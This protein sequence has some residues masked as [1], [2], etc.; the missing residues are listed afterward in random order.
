MTKSMRAVAATLTLGSVLLVSACGS[1][2]STKTGSSSTTSSTM[3]SSPSTSIPSMSSLTTTHQ[4][5]DSDSPQARSAAVI[6]NYFT[7]HDACMN[8]PRSAQMTCFDSVAVS[9]ELNNL[10]NALSS[11]K[12]AYT[13]QIG[14]TRVVWAKRLK[15]DLTYKPKETPPSI[16][17]VTYSVCY[18]VS[19]V[20]VVDYQGKSI[21]PPSRK[22]RAIETIAVVDYRYP[23]PAGWRV[24]YTQPTGKPC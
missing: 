24:V 16:P 4:S 23:N 11:A 6:A 10:R 9:T 20:N 5:A 1:G 3:S 18:D 22:P 14:S 7:V 19:K 12:V 2:G 15:V 8:N 21:V 13:K 17:I